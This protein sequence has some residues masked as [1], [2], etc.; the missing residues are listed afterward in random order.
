M[1]LPLHPHFFEVLAGLEPGGPERGGPERGGPE[2]GGR[3][4]LLGSLGRAA[5]ALGPSDDWTPM[6]LLRAY[7]AVRGSL[8]ATVG[9]QP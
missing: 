1:P 5:D 2:R 7:C 4:R 6:D 9:E 3:V 8:C